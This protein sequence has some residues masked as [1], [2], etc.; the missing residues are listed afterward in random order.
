[1]P[2][3]FVHVASQ[4]RGRTLRCPPA[5]FVKSEDKSVF[6]SHPHGVGRVR[7]T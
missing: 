5:V 3:V 4:L 1:M 2:F 6:V 7:S